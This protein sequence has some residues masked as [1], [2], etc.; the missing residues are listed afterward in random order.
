MEY[1]AIDLHLRH[2]QIRIVRED[3]SVVAD[4]RISTS[5]DALTALYGTGSVRFCCRAAS[6]SNHPSW[7]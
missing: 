1:G 3:G 6:V 4:R 7:N 5:R 2:S